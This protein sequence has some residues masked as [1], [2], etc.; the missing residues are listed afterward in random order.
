MKDKLL[1]R[2][3]ASSLPL[4]EAMESEEEIDNNVGSLMEMLNSKYGH[5]MEF[6]AEDI[7]V[8]YHGFDSRIDWETYLLCINGNA[9]LFLNGEVRGLKIDKNS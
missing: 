1:V 7:T 2:A 8:K 9:V 5:F 4:Q 3:A 6:T